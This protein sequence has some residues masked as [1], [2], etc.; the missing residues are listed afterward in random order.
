MTQSKR[1]EYNKT[2][3]ITIQKRNK[4]M[5]NKIVEWKLQGK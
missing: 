3:K 4:A 1:Q 2:E 5:K